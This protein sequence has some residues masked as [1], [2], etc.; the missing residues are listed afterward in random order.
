MYSL[1]KRIV[2][3]TMKGK[4]WSSVNIS[5]TALT[6][7]ELQLQYSMEYELI[8]SAWNKL[9]SSDSET[10]HIRTAQGNNVLKLSSYC[11]SAVIIV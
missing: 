3:P 2:G 4:N 8:M 11:P 5:N 9:G 6:R 10:W 1:H 7:Y